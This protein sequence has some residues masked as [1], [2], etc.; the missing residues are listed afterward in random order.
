MSMLPNSL[1]NLVLKL[2]QLVMLLKD[3][4]L[5]NGMAWRVR[6]SLAGSS[7]LVRVNLDFFTCALKLVTPT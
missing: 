3:P 2:V 1:I 6:K 5:C 4:L 7:Q